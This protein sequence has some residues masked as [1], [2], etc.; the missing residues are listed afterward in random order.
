M[1]YT[2]TMQALREGNAIARRTRASLA[3]LERNASEACA[4]VYAGNVRA[5]RVAMRK[6]RSACNRIDRN[7]ERESYA[8][9]I[10]WAFEYAHDRCAE[11]HLEIGTHL[12]RM[13]PTE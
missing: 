7:A 12:Y 6:M 2:E 10:G 5:A 1:T 13:E 3:T 11:T 8:G 4:R 9:A